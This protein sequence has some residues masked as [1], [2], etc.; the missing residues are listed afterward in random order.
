MKSLV[1]SLVAAL[2]LSTFTGCAYHK[3]YPDH[4]DERVTASANN[5]VKANVDWIKNKNAAVDVRLNI[6]NPTDEPIFIKASD[7]T[8]DFG[9]KHAIGRTDNAVTVVQPGQT[10]KEVFI[11]NTGKGKPYDGTAKITIN[12]IYKGTP[13]APKGN[14][15]AMT[16]EVPVHK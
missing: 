13:A 14:L 7:V 4:R 1:G 2:V 15:A 16:I 9:D 11:F 3:N 5:D 12:P 8:L 10:L 6:T